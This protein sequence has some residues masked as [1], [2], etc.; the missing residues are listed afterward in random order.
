MSMARALYANHRRRSTPPGD[1]FIRESHAAEG[2]ARQAPKNEDSS[3]RAHLRWREVA[4]PRP[5]AVSAKKLP[6]EKAGAH[7]F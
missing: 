1:H 6:F 5:E 7:R 2:F 3:C 4:F